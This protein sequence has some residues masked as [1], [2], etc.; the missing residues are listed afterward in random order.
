MQNICEIVV[1]QI[2][3]IVKRGKL[4]VTMVD[5]KRNE[6]WCDIISS[7]SEAV[8]SFFIRIEVL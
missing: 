6:G 4:V 3:K 5:V 2:R 7:F 1:N 8:T